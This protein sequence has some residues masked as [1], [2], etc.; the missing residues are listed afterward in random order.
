MF[1]GQIPEMRIVNIPLH[2]SGNPD[3]S[4]H[5][6]DHVSFDFEVQRRVSV[7]WG[8]K[9]NLNQ[10]RLQ[11][12]VYEDVK[13]QDLKAIVDVRHILADIGIEEVLNW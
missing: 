4:E 10:P 1:W 3:Q 6:W 5:I 13:P 8:W 11:G 2:V 7:H 9:I 12:G